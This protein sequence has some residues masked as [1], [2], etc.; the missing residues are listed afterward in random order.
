MQLQ[1]YRAVAG[2]EDSHQAKKM[3]DFIRFR[4]LYAKNCYMTRFSF[5]TFYVLYTY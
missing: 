5:L 3:E 4:I 1:D 2:K